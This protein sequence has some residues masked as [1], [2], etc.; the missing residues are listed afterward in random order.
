MTDTPHNQMANA[1]RALAMD[2][3]QRANSGHPGAPMGMA[4][5]ATVLFTQVL[6]FD[7]ADPKWPDRDRWVLSAG[8]A[9]MLHYALNHLV[10]Y[11]DMTMDQ[12]KNFRQLDSITAGHPEYG[13]ALGIET[14]TGPLG[15]GI[16]TAVG[17]AI[18]ERLD[19]AR[20]GDDLVD[21]HTYVFVGDGC[22]MEGIS[23]EAIDMAGHMKLSRMIV[24]WDDNSI[25]IDGGTDMS[26]S[27]DQ[28]ARFAAAG[29]DAV[30]IDGHDPDAI[31]AALEA[32]RNSDQP[33]FIACKTII[34]YGAPTKQGTHA[35]HGAPLGDEEIAGTRKA[36]GW[37]AEPFEIPD[38]V[39]TAWRDAGSRGAETRAAWQERLDTSSDKATFEAAHS[40]KIPGV[41]APA[42][43][44]YKKKMVEEAPKPGVVGPA[45]RVA[46]Q[47]AL[48]V[49]NKAIP[50][51]IGGSA[52]LTGSNNTKTSGMEAVTADDFSGSYMYYGVREHGMAAAMNGIALHGGFI[53][54]GGTFLVFADYMRG[55]MRLAALMGLR[56]GYVLTHDSIDLGEDGPTHQPVET[57]ASLRAMPNM[58]VFRPCD[59]VETAEAW[60]CVVEA[61]NTPSVLALTR[62]G[63]PL[64]R[65][66]HTETNM[67]A[68]GG[69]V[70]RDTQ[71]ERDVTLIATGSE[72]SLAS[73]AADALAK[74]GIN[75]AVVSLPCWELFDAQ[76]AAYRSEV[77]GTAP[78]VAV[79]AAVG[80]GWEK[81]IG[82]NGT[83]IGMSSFGASA[84]YKEL[85]KKFGITVDA[86]VD[87]AKA[88]Q[89]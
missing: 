47:M 33:S 67:T 82:D 25:T 49:V 80:M 72:V 62:Q 74:E 58:N 54:Y 35:T 21:H 85:Y 76:D 31:A 83:F 9:S 16:A 17:M 40:G 71:G 89:A 6:K 66:Q 32:A 28:V 15:Q 34:G 63:R 8:H 4:D 79:E 52:D 36:L 11:K 65:T 73:E 24:L 81:Y 10:G 1:I 48:E 46:S 5:M 44:E 88:L 20:F 70:L 45:T 84:P 14:T 69:Y 41:L 53:P 57:I 26:T 55:A 3:V 37:T 51:T 19:N 43:N 7:A 77:L 78:R 29:W 30:A 39:L 13:H 12:I 56:V 42:I 68:L 86:V 75:A 38:D 18:A 64:Q 59:V 22:L 61:E 87:A 2:G 27:T 60:Q 50:F 23:H